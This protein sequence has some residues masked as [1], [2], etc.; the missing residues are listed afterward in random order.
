MAKRKLAICGA[1]WFSSDLNYPGKSFGEI[2]A[3]RHDMELISLARG[4]CSNFT[5]SLQ[6]NQAIAM[7]ADL[8][9]LGTTEPDRI[10]IPIVNSMVQTLWDKFKNNFN[11]GNWFNYQLNAYDRTRG[12]ANIQYAPHTDLSSNHSFLTNPTLVS[13]S[14]NN[15]VFRDSPHN[16]YNLTNDQIEAIKHYMVSMYDASSKRQSDIWIIND[17]CRRLTTASIPFLLFTSE[18]YMQDWEEDIK[19]LPSVNR[20]NQQL[21]EL[22]PFGQNRFHYDPSTGGDVIADF[23][24]E[25]LQE[26]GF[27]V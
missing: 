19:W 14:L 23:I 10:E 24:E 3:T 12:L 22:T 16:F 4:G 17:T 8:V 27:N 9:I 21:S 20:T 2:L 26:L 6:V 7:G 11:W 13:E 1:S 25:K 15:L 5:I 18:L